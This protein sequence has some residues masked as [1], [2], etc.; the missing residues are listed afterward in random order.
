MEFSSDMNLQAYFIF[1]AL[2]SQKIPCRDQPTEEYSECA[3]TCRDMIVQSQD[4]GEDWDK[5]KLLQL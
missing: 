2:M 1:F 3:L 5:L 4:C